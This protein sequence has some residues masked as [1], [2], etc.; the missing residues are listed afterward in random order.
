MNFETR[1]PFGP[2]CFGYLI[3]NLVKI[4]VELPAFGDKHH[5]LLSCSIDFRFLYLVQ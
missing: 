5:I 3:F 1:K 2:I 4:M